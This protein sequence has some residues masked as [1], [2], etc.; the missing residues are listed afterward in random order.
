MDK[1]FI[2]FEGPD[3]CGKS[4]QINLL[5]EYLKEKHP[6]TYDNMIFTREPGGYNSTISEKIRELLLDPDNHMSDITEAYLYAA[7]RAEHCNN[8]QEWLSEGKSVITDRFVFSSYVYQGV[9]RGLGVQKVI[10]INREAIEN[11]RPSLIIYNRVNF[12]TYLK[13]K[14]NIANLDRLE[15]NDEKFFR[16]II[17]AYDNLMNSNINGYNIRVVDANQPIEK[18]H[19]DILKI[20]NL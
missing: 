15:Q 8:I 1:Q 9:A 17:D 19:A 2:V 13:R 5:K 12:E 3:H 11:L 6:D 20:L 18:V 14:G 4:L 10:E 7:S 16:S